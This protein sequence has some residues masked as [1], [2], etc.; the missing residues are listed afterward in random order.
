MKTHLTPFQRDRI[1]YFFQK[2]YSTSMIVDELGFN[3]STINYTI[4]RLKETGSIYDRSRPGRPLIS[5]TRD[6]RR[7]INL[8]RKKRMKSSTWLSN[9]WYLSSDKKASARTVRR[10]LQS[11]KY[12]WC[13][14]VRKPRL[15]R[16]QRL[17][18]K[19]WC[20]SRISWNSDKWR[21]VIFSDEMNIEVDV[22]KCRPM[23]RRMAH[24][25]Y[26]SDCIVQR[27]K[28]GSGS[29]GIWACMNYY[30]KIS[31]HIFEGRLNAVRYVEILKDKLS[32][33][34]EL[35]EV[36]CNNLIYQQDGAP[37]HRAKMT[38]DWLKFENIDLLPW[39][40]NSPD[41]NCIENLWSWLDKQLIH[42]NPRNKEEL[43][44]C[45][46]NCLE[47]VPE[48]IIKNLIDSMPRR[49]SECVK[50]KGGQTRY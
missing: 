2:G 34:V 30:G 8:T 26:N 5:T 12:D 25:K 1:I 3:K 11:L 28:Q 32:K 14:A 17:T 37:C 29:I 20:K 33:F 45:V 16:K 31:Y 24:E 23:I 43:I 44:Q 27:T 36:N 49:V 35:S 15:S 18:R 48:D 13:A 38:M 42:A 4:K 21:S 50:N 6:D 9:N 46:S 19:E 10:R 39:P 40:A 41:L 22:R 7:L 47:N